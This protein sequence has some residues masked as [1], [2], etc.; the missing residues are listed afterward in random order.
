MTQLFKNNATGSLASSIG[1]TDTLLALATGHGA[2]F[3]TPTGGDHFQLTLVGLDVNG[4]EASWE[5]VR[6]TARSNDSLTVVRA[7]ENTSALAWPAGARVEL[8]VTAGTLD[9]F[10]DT[11][12]AAAAAP[13]QSV[14]GRTGAV[15]LGSGDVT[16]AL[17]FTPENAANKGIAGGYAGL[18]GSGLVPASQLPSYVDDVLEYANSAA[19]PA[20]G[21]TGKI[22]VALDTGRTWRWSGSVYTQ[23]I[24]SPGTTDAITEGASNLFFTNARAQAALAG[25]YLPIGGGSVTGS[26]DVSG[27][28][29]AGTATHYGK[30]N[31]FSVASG[32]PATSGTTDAAIN[33]RMAVSAIALDFGVYSSGVSWLQNRLSADLSTNYGL[34]LN[35]NGGPVS[36]GGTPVAGAL[37]SL[38]NL[39]A[40]S[41]TTPVAITLG[42]TFSSVAGAN[43]KL[44]V[45]EGNG[46]AYGLGV[47]SGSLDVVAPAA[48]DVNL[49]AG[50]VKGLTLSQHGHLLAGEAAAVQWET[51]TY[52]VKALQINTTNLFDRKG[53]SSYLSQ[54]AYWDGSGVWRYQ[55]AMGATMLQLAS[56]GVNMRVAAV[57]TPGGAITWNQFFQADAN[58]AVTIQGITV[59]NGGGAVSTN[60]AVGTS[61]LAGSNSGTGLNTGLGYQALQSNT[62]GSYNTA[63]GVNSVQATTTGAFNSGFG[64]QALQ[65]NTTGSYNTA[66]GQAAL[67][68]NTTASNNTAVGYQAGYSN[69]TGDYNTFVG[70]RSG[71]GVTTGTNNTII[72]ID[73][74]YSLTTGSFNTFI[75]SNAAAYSSGQLITTGSKNTIL[76]PY[77]GNQGGLDIRTASNNIVLSDGDGNPRYNINNRGNLQNTMSMSNTLFRQVTRS[78]GNATETFT[79]GDMGMTD[80]VTCLILVSVGG[81]TTHYEYGSTVIAWCMPRGN[82]SFI[83][84]TVVAAYKG[85]NTGTFSVAASGNSLV[86]S[87]DSDLNVSITIIGGGGT[88]NI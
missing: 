22:Y 79:A 66:V 74:G 78:G 18:D 5:I 24:A 53:G 45:F 31:T 13:V 54:N 76:G 69:T 36:I 1:T 52:A 19:F 49:Y 50:G 88:S 7:Q 60:T 48:A 59:G 62:T 26:V 65:S 57:G 9:S 14:F 30:L 16:G 23:I 37:L 77:S 11:A 82:A 25:M 61:A 12:Q 84:T 87:K 15:V 8:R 63:V 51:G 34:A 38:G 27:G 17:G 28:L 43:L 85:A 2:R 6:C 70:R 3:P 41:T 21:V 47:S 32:S 46:V 29:S 40:T 72:G 58:G 75:G 83:Q 64:T 55:Q 71:Y 4:N 67:L 39:T 42:G 81:T 56:S 35:P 80:N 68:Y 10:T 44:K 86:V 73:A 33:W 20:I